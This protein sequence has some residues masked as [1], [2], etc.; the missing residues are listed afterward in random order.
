MKLKKSTILELK[1]ILKEEFNLILDR[2]NLEKLAYS[3]ISYFGLLAKIDYKQ[4][5][6]GNNSSTLTSCVLKLPY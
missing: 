1:Q 3:L 2:K 6:F 4:G 5:K